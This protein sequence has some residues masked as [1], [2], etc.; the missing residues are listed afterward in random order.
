MKIFLKA[1]HWQLFL[2]TFAIPFFLYMSGIVIMIAILATQRVHDPYIGLRFLP[3]FI[4]IGLIATAVQYGWMWASGIL[5]NNRLPE[6]LRLNT[7]FFKICF[8]YPFIY[9]PIVIIIV[10]TNLPPDPAM[11]PLALLALIPFHIFAIF[12]SFYCYYFVAR[13]VKTNEMGMH[14][15]VNDYIAEIFMIWF[16][17]I[18]IWFLQPKINKIIS[19]SDNQE[20]TG[21]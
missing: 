8:F 16:F 19:A 15:T 14:T 13:I 9:I 21:Q 3:F 5:L 1:K 12:C 17:F 10:F 11:F 7:V 4:F 18:G 2:L 6:E 20:V